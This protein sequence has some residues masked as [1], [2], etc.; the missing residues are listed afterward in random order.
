MIEGR[1]L[2]VPLVSG[3]INDAAADQGGGMTPYDNLELKNGLWQTP[4]VLSVRRGSYLSA[5]AYQDDQGTPADVTSL[6]HLDYWEGAQ[7]LI[8]L[9]HS[10]VTDKHYLYVADPDGD[11]PQRKAMPAA[12]NVAS[13]VKFSTVGWFGDRFYGCDVGQ[14]LGMWKF[15]TTTVTVYQA[16]GANTTKPKMIFKHMNHLM[17]I[18]ANRD[19]TVGAD[20]LLFSNIGDPDTVAAT[21]FEGIGADEEPLTIGVSL[22]EYAMLFK[23]REIYQL[24]GSGRQSWHFRPIDL[25]RGCIG[26]RHAIRYGPYV[27]FVSEQGFC[28]VGAGG[29]SQLIV[30]RVRLKWD[31]LDNLDNV[32]VTV[33]PHRRLVIFGVHEVGASGTYA[34]KL[35]GVDWR[36]GAWTE[37]PYGFNATHGAAVPQGG[38]PA[39]AAPPTYVAETSVGTNGWTANWTN[40]ETRSGTS[41]R[42]ESQDV[43][44]GGGFIED[45][46]L[47]TG[48]T[49]TPISGKLSGRHYKERVR[50]ERF[51]LYSVYSAEG[52]VYTKCGTPV[53]DA[54]SD[55][56]GNVDVW[57]DVPDGYPGTVVIQ[58][59]TTEFGAYSTVH[60]IASPVSG[61]NYWQDSP[62]PGTYWYKAYV[63]RTSH[64]DSDF[65]NA[66]SAVAGGPAEPAEGGCA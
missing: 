37:L 47:G 6:C 1:R 25:D 17:M 23:D 32:F 3:G 45:K 38:A 31:G 40:G 55:G 36:T 26:P 48:V 16:D 65:S 19:G 33:D 2:P 62:A 43:D 66:N 28:R 27:W 12:Y 53:M 18:G 52:D 54:F 51:G 46:E 58:R 59:A 57:V 24:S 7:A 56:L 15:N 29:P 41:T 64:A 22:G 30:D 34:S 10:T 5:T 4:S 49:T 60:T 14:S 44:G 63:T 13:P 9:G 50:H 61:C 39:P 20:Q 8:V 42:H 35:L 11:N 21:N